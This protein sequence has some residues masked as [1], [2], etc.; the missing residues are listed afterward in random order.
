MTSQPWWAVVGC[1][2]D[3]VGLSSGCC[4]SFLGNILEDLEVRRDWLGIRG[5]MQ[6][7]L[8]LE[9]PKVGKGQNERWPI[10]LCPSCGFGKSWKP[11]QPHVGSSFLD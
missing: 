5:F 6:A 10:D 7:L 3:L 11:G 2:G 8:I 1:H 4:V 9:V